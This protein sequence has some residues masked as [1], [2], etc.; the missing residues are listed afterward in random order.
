M[1]IGAARE[2]TI[3][4][5]LPELCLLMRE[6]LRRLGNLMIRHFSYRSVMS[7]MVTVIKSLG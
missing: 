3:A 5:I 2:V 1:T 4:Y 7:P 6:G